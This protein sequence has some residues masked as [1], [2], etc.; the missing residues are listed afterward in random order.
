MEVRTD[1]PSP[2]QIVLVDDHEA[3][4]NGIIPILR[5]HY[6]NAKLSSAKTCESAW[7]LIEQLKPDLVLVDLSIP[8]KPGEKA[9]PSTGLDFIERL[10]VLDSA[11]NIMVMTAS[12]QALVRI[13]PT[14]NIYGGGFSALDKADS[15]DRVPGLLDIAMRGAIHLPAILRT[16]ISFEPTWLQVMRHRFEEGM[17]DRAI[18]KSMGVSDRTIRNYW[19]RIQDRLGISDEPGVD[20]RIKVEIEAR[21]LGLIG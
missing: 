15:L 4:L 1:R 6:P 16:R 13:K 20:S 18:A 19:I 21:R 9:Q 5:V 10:M 17:T 11:P 8:A 3:V 12:I 14:I 7:T 2:R